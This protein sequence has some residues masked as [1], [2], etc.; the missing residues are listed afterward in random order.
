M[1]AREEYP[2]IILNIERLCDPYLILS[3]IGCDDGS[4]GNDI[5]YSLN[6]LVRQPVIYTLQFI[7]DLIA[8]DLIRVNGDA[9]LAI[10]FFEAVINAV[11]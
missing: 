8:E 9:G 6:K 1:S 7:T 10:L 4:F 11:K 3:D 2:L 5:T